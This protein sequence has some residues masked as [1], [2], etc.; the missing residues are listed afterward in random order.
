MTPS[1]TGWRMNSD[2]WLPTAPERAMQTKQPVS[3]ASA[4]RT[5]TN[6]T[7]IEGERAVSGLL[8]A[9]VHVV[10]LEFAV[11]RVL[12]NAE[13]AG[14]GK[15]VTPGFAQGA[16]NRAALQ[17]LE[18]QD[19]IFFRDALGGVILKV[20]RKIRDMEN[21]PE[22]QRHGALD[23]V[24]QLA[25][26]SGPI[27]GD[28]PAHGVFRNRAHRAL[29]VG[30]FL[31]KCRDEDGDITLAVPQRRQFDLH[32]I[33]TE[34]QILPESSRTN[35]RVQIAVSG[36]DD[37]DIDLA[38]FGGADG[39][40]FALLQRTQELGLQIHGHVS[41]FIEK[42]RAPL[43]GFEQTLLGLH[44]PGESALDVA[45]QLGFDQR[46]DQRRTVHRRKGAVFARPRKMNAAGHEFFPRS[47]LPEDENGILMLADFFDDFVDTLHFYGDTDQPAEPWPRAQLLAQQAILLL[48]FH[49][50]PHAF[51]AG[52]QLLNAERLGDVIDGAKTRNLHSGFN[53][54]VLRQ[55][56]DGN[57]GM[58]AV[59]LFE[60]LYAA[61]S[62][63]LQIRQE[64]VNG[65]MFQNLQRFFRGSHGDGFHSRLFGNRGTGLTDG[66]LVIHDENVHRDSLAA[67]CCFLSHKRTPKSLGLRLY[68]HL[69]FRFRKSSGSFYK[70]IR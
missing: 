40:D 63:Q 70:S 11:Q 7:R 5:H 67:D 55:H 26:V 69:G 45:E 59:H 13:Q 17:F 42:E 54:A 64:D 1:D 48:E 60:Q 53:G 38:A 30:E 28:Q 35:G 4:L 36:S 15:L 65:R 51:E 31:Q 57:F 24:F 50:A 25:D 18:R 68:L 9:V 32:D 62:L 39:L 16:K 34:I 19:F 56:D 66:Q 12:A 20:R 44:G 10:L 61:R 49:R 58:L 6:R 23:G 2:T 47:A 37:A 52:A 3:I 43:G 22:A 41:D 33:Q 14:R 21:R 29:W 27:V 8:L 46:G